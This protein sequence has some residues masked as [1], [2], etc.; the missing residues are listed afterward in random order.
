MKPRAASK[1]VRTLLAI[2]FAICIMT[3]IK[4]QRTFAQPNERNE[5]TVTLIPLTPVTTDLTPKDYRFELVYNVSSFFLNINNTMTNLTI[6]QGMLG[7]VYG[8]HSISSVTLQDNLG[9]NF[10]PIIGDDKVSNPEAWSIIPAGFEYR[11]SL[12]FSTDYGVVFDAEKMVYGV[13]ISGTS[14]ASQTLRL[15]L[16]QN[17]TILECT[18]NAAQEEDGEQITLRWP[19]DTVHEVFATFVPFNLQAIVRSFAFTVDIPSVTPIGMIEGSIEENF[20][21]PASFSIWPINP[22]FAI[23]VDFPNYAQVLDVSGVSDGI[24]PCSGLSEA[25]VKLDNNSLGHYYVDNTNRVL[26]VYPRYDY[27]GDFYN[28]ALRATFIT[29]PEYKPFKMEAV[30]EDALPYRYES[31]FIIDKVFSPA[32][33]KMNITGNVEIKFILPPGAQISTGESGS[34]EVGVEDGRPVALF[35]YNS[36]ITVSPSRWHVIYEMIDQRNLFLLEMGSLISFGILGILLAVLQSRVARKLI[37]VLTS[38]VFIPVLLLNVQVYTGIGWSKPIFLYLLIG[39][40]ILS[41]TCMTIL[42]WKSWKN[43]SQRKTHQCAHCGGRARYLKSTLSRRHFVK[44]YRC[45]K[46]G[47][48]S[49]LPMVWRTEKG[50]YSCKSCGTSGLRVDRVQT[51]KFRNE[52]NN[53]IEVQVKCPKCGS[54]ALTRIQLGKEGS[55]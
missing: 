28:Y 51:G 17:F 6:P 19:Q 34:P 1:H 16:P 43:Y 2:L 30:K 20:T 49:Q 33:W 22:M 14:A 26:I 36:P 46:C 50:G 52:R 40:L 25:P 8:N 18:P 24:G 3:T 7:W 29:P 37:S 38:V 35:V 39:E 41:S 47:N 48:I 32:N 11:I 10:E 23:N 31:Y 44:E 53:S 54:L 13:A 4:T 27:K 42:G 55:T 21:A 45:L 5:V 15:Q 9:H 12:S